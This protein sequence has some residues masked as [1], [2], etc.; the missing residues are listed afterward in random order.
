MIPSYTVFGNPVA[1]SKSPQI[2]QY[3]ARQEGVQIEYTRTLVDN[4]RADFDNAVRT[5]L[6]QGG[7]GANITLPFKHF[8]YDFAD[9]HSE[10]AQAAGAV[11]TFVPQQDGRILGDNTDGEGLVRDLREHLGIE[12]RGKRILLLGA[13]GAARG[14]VLPLLA[15]RPANLT[16][17]NRTYSKA[18]ELAGIFRIEAAPLTQLQPCYDIIINATSSSLHHA[19]PDVPP[20]IFAGCFLAY[21]LFYA[22]T[23][24]AFMQFA[25]QHGT[26]QT[27]DGLGMLVGQAAAAYEQWRGFAPDIAPVIRHFR[28]QAAE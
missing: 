1:H 27:A 4:T 10:R 16:I 12:L 13:G 5:F 20:D 11:N 21:D 23:A 8:A 25:A 6:Q 19:A 9:L 28:A 14:V 24:T 7:A 18:V 15:H 2:H 26:Q 3:F 17:A 22:D